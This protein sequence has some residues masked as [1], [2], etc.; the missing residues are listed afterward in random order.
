M[1]QKWI[2]FLLI[3]LAFSDV[4][5]QGIEQ[6]IPGSKEPHAFRTRLRYLLQSAEPLGGQSSI[7]QWVH[8]NYAAHLNAG[9]EF[10][11]IHTKQSALGMHYTYQPYVNG[12]PVLGTSMRV[13][14]D[15]QSKIR[16]IQEQLPPT[17]ALEFPNT[18]LLEHNA[19]LFSENGLVAGKYGQEEVDG[20]KRSLFYQDN[21]SIFDLGPSKLYFMEPDSFAWARVFAP[22]P[23]VTHRS[24]YGGQLSDRGDQD[25]DSLTAALQWVRMKVQKKGDTAQLSS[26]FLSFGHVSDPIVET[27]VSGNDTFQYTRSQRAFEQVNAFYHLQRMSE[28][29]AVMGFGNLLDSIIIDAHA[30]NG[31]DLSA[32]DPSVYP[33]T[34][35]FGEGGVDDAE[36][37]QVVIHEFGHALSTIGSSGT[38]SGSQRRSMEEGNA[39]YLCM[40]YSRGYSDYAANE[41]FS[42][43]GH[44]EFWEGFS[45]NTEKKYP[46]DLTNFSDDD[47]EIW[48]TALMCIFDE[49]GKS[50]A[51][52]LV[53]EHLFYQA[54]N[55][56]MPDMAN[57]ILGINDDFFGGK[58]QW[59]IQNCFAERGIL[60]YSN[61]GKPTME[62]FAV[63]K[64]SE[65]FANGSG[66]AI[67]QL[68]AHSSFSWSLYNLN[69]ALIQQG[70]GN[71][72]NIRIV[73]QGLKNG[74]YFLHL[75]AGE[76]HQS[77]KL[78]RY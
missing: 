6:A 75:T 63:L 59:K 58:D 77:F 28:Q 66:S 48:S 45:V 33:Y 16:W 50:K 69:G 17:E 70:E 35:E 18:N 39:D 61:T 21:G 15:E 5:A 14:L 53:L 65:S 36:D 19:L 22:N 43:D 54:A 71:G 76:E 78:I 41:V 23:I 10:R 62:A 29:I 4:N 44:N 8:S 9:Y 11:L 3:L 67:I 74:M 12:L 49:I 38:V 56:N 52:S 30:F 31:A 64:G 46:Q 7:T 13:H 55:S 51:D 72:A 1:I 25:S 32:F 24:S 34:L 27:V 26:R 40:S 2:G 60:P 37:A 20:Q 68:P 57:I 47:R 73:P 42:W